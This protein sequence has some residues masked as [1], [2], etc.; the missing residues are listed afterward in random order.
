MLF[1]AA[2][3][4]D[5]IDTGGVSI[6]G[7]PQIRID[8]AI[9]QIYTTRV[10]DGGFCDGDQIGLFG[11]N[12]SE[13]NTVAGTLVDKGNQVDNAR[14]TYD[15]ANRSWNSSGSIYYK[16][17]NTNIDLYAYYP[18]GGIDSVN[19]Y[20]FE[21]AQDQSGN[22][23]TDGYSQSDFLW[24]KTENVVPSQDK[25]KIKFNHILACANVLLIEG[26]GFAE[27]E[28]AELE[29]GVLVMNTTRTAEIDLSTGI[30]TPA[31]K[32]ASEG[33]VMKS[34]AEGFRAIVVP[35]SVEASVALFSITV[36]GISYRYKSSDAF[37][38]EA[39]KQS[40]FTIKINKKEHSGT[41]EFVLTDTEIVD[42]VADLDSHG[43]EAR[44]YYVV[45]LDEAGA[46]EEKI[47]ADKK[48]P[49]KIKNL[50]VSGKINAADFYFM[51]DK[52]D[53]LQSINLKEAQIVDWIWRWWGYIDEEWKD[54]YITT[55]YPDSWEDAVAQVQAK[56][57]NASIDH[58]GHSRNENCG[59]GNDA[60]P[61]YAFRDKSTLVN[62]VFPEKV[63]KIGASAFNGCSLL[64]GAL[65]IPDDVV[66]ICD[67]AFNSCSN[68]TSLSLPPHLEK[69]GI[70]AFINCSALSGNLGLP[71]S[72]TYIE[73]GAFQNCSGFTGPLVLPD[74]LEYLGAQ[75]F[76][77]CSGFTGDIVIPTSLTK[78]YWQTFYQCS[79]LNG[80]LVLHDGIT[81][82]GNEAFGGCSFQG[83][84]KLPANLLKIPGGCFANCQ[85]SSI[86]EFPKGLIEIGNNAFAGNWRL[87]GTLELPD[88]LVA[89]GENAFWGC[90]TLEG[91]VLP[92][93]LAIL[94]SSVFRNCYYLN[95]IV[96]K[97]IEPPY[98]QSG[99]FDGV[100]KDNFAVEV[101]EQSVNR[102]QNSSGWNE[103][104]RI[105]AHH[106]FTISRRLMRTLNAEHT[107]EF[108][109]RAPSGFAWSVESMPEWVTV[110]PS[111]GVGKTEVTVTV[112]EMTAAEV[113]EF[114][115]NTGS[116]NDPQYE[117]NRGRAG[118]IVFLLDG[119]DYR[120]TMKVE[121][122]DYQYGDGDVIANQTATKGGGVNLVFMGDCF[123][124]RDIAR[125][126]Y[127]NGINEAIGYYFD[128]EPYKTYREYF[129]VYT[130]FGMSN[131]SGMGT[132]N[133][134][135]DAK[136]GSQYSLAGITPN[137]GTTY[138]YA[139]K[140]TT[141]NEDNIGQTLV[142][143][144]ENTTEYGGIC[145]MWSDG[146]AIACCPM[147]DDAFPY[148]FRGIVQHEAGGHGFAKLADE[149]IYTNA[150]IS[151][152]VC[153]N[154]HLLDFYAGKSLG[155]YRNLEDTGDMDQV[156][157][158]HLIFHP[159]YSNIVD[160][161]EGGYFHT[162]GIFRSEPNS[163]MN[164]NIPY[165]SAI[166]R[167]EAVERIM[168]YAGEKFDIND[169]YAKDVL[170]TYGNQTG[171]TRVASEPNAIT[172]TGAGKQMPPKFM[173]E[174]PFK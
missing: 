102:Y 116:Y 136:F 171:S 40:K 97:A 8:G 34:N 114:E 126:S 45:H 128:I 50:K 156:G 130:V 78:I 164:N 42:W 105:V 168:R 76:Y 23:I 107:R 32:A 56:Y 172:L 158:S 121:Q 138:E 92:A 88:E 18:Y 123:D 103:F 77:W 31:G 119:K 95:K 120:A 20:N 74:N 5:A 63:T 75:A 57:P 3:T 108:V 159:T 90:S 33:I 170:D 47:L 104:K 52:M 62:F 91:V 93:E 16:D 71:S 146:S 153:P 7:A 36:D 41:Y 19:G 151:A 38:Y 80:R 137:H 54:L 150:F 49:A 4:T 39:G 65:I 28:F 145:Y 131:D 96:C 12:Y 142:V 118:E 44:Q 140:A 117:N 106:D 73:G 81:E 139:M 149:Y 143:M 100:A 157:W 132:V 6:E 22:T 58:Y 86:A 147:S 144:I 167:Q 68:I 110:T 134:I 173:G 61:E 15:E 30:A 162:R 83:E 112:A 53:I 94:K 37:T 101:P 29:K 122:Y 67:D 127:I 72:L 115:I 64:A 59:K 79:G 55:E 82:I 13:D 125:G 46:L 135:R 111:S 2:C 21:V 69:I 98:V 89:L 155:W 169:F 9:N 166:S 11:V 160:V 60:I 14:Y 124:A 109:L 10:D 161:Y 51:R 85:F 17:T 43:G 174:S 48:N 133:T 113:G 163:C 25:V 24:G 66:E 27:G 35:Q 165:F 152:C 26:N 87:M 129:N 84:L 141:V 148:D 154:P 99:A 1:A 70:Q